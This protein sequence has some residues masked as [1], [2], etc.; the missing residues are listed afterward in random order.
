MKLRKIRLRAVESQQSLFFYCNLPMAASAA[1]L[2]S[3]ARKHRLRERE[4]LHLL[5]TAEHL[6]AR[7]DGGGDTPSNIVSAHLICNMRRH[8]TPTPMP[9]DAYRSHVQIRCTQGKWHSARVLHMKP[10]N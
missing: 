3:F 7:C 10:G 1:E 2:Q 5:A 9:P 6:L 8:R 4:A